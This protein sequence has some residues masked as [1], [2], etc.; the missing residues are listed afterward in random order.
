M[1]Y[2]Y[3]LVCTCKYTLTLC[4]YVCMWMSCTF[5][6]TVKTYIRILLIA[7]RKR[8]YVYVH[9]KPVSTITES[10][11]TYSVGNGSSFNYLES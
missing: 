1:T 6:L 9:A 3:I 8:I 4:N 11:K 2:T 7:I 5:L 10:F